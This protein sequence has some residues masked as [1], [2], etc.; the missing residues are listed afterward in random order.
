MAVQPILQLGNP[1]LRQRCVPVADPA[2]PEVRDLVRDLADTLAHWRSETGY[3]RGIAA[4]QIGVLQRVV[5]LQLPGEKPWPFINPEIVRRS[6]Q[7]IVVWDACLSFLSIFMQVERHREITVRYQ[8]L[9]GHV[10]EVEASEENNLSELLQHEIDHLDGILA[11]D[12]VTD[13]KTIVTREEFEKRYLDASPYADTTLSR[14][15]KT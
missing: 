3:G 11:I 8:K 14:A 9:D 2:S 12:R 6:E 7:K 13:L 4:P 10:I 15:V 5:F 1:V